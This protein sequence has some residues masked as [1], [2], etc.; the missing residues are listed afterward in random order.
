M[1]SGVGWRPARSTAGSVAGK[2]LKT[3]K[4]IALTTNS[5]ATIP[6]SRRTMNPAMK[7]GP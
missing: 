5:S 6:I 1:I 3:T 4:T 7:C 2:T